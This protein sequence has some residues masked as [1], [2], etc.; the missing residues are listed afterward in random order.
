MS[1]RRMTDTWLDALSRLERWKSPVAV[2]WAE[3]LDR[4]SVWRLLGVTVRGGALVGDR[5]YRY[6]HL[7]L[8]SRMQPPAD[9]ARNLREGRVLRSMG[10]REFR[11]MQPTE[12]GA[13]WLTSGA[14][15]GM[16]APL[17]TPSYY[18]SVGLSSADL[19]SQAE[20]GEP[21]FG[22]GQPYYPSGQDAILEVLFGVTK[23][24]GW[25]DMVNQVLIQLPYFDAF[26][27]QARYVEGAGVVVS[28][29][30]A[31]TGTVAG[32]EL[33][34]LWKIHL[35]EFSY[36]RDSRA[37]KEAGDVT[38]PFDVKPAYFSA[39]LQDP[40]GLLVD[41]IELQGRPDAQQQL[42][43]IASDALPEAFDFLA[44]VWSNVTRFDLFAVRRV[45]PAAELSVPV[46]TRSDFSGRLSAFGD[47]LKAI[48]VDDSLVDAEAAKGLAED[49]SI[50]RLKLAVQKLLAS[51]Q[52]DS[53]TDALN[54]LR[55]IVRVRVAIQHQHA[56]PD[57][58]TALARLGIAHP[59]DW[60]QA[61]EI[62][63]HRAVD[64]LREL[65]RA[66]ESALP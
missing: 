53:A 4:D 23:H 35:S 21:A 13:Y 60:A 1:A 31:D 16:I 48:R 10:T 45:A 12:G 29:G 44:S 25:R 6:A 37:L 8:R 38:F 54:I 51:P 28:V 15:F 39:S 47:L 32:H 30:E 62:V 36:Q 27:H 11:E 5:E 57:L 22:P 63:R 56:T 41:T 3:A 7:R 19:V 20:L 17:P 52:L 55:D 61:W 18:F 65:R 49:S 58:P 59:P 46:A 42:Q 33:Q 50:G 66:L 34:A 14:T 26:I 64:A 9:T 40:Y 43:P 24:Q 2:S